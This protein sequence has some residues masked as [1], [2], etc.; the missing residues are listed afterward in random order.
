MYIL[1]SVPQ[2]LKDHLKA[3]TQ[4]ILW[5]FHKGWAMRHPTEEAFSLAHNITSNIS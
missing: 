2:S 3:L 4:I 5:S 1:A